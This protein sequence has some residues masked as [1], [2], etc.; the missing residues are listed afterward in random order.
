MINTCHETVF[1]PVNIQ[2]EEWKLMQAMDFGDD[3]ARSMCVTNYQSGRDVDSPG[4]CTYVGT[5]S[6]W[7][8]FV[9]LVQFWCEPK[10][11]LRNKVWLHTY[12]YLA[13]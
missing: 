9:L 5:R 4:S 12:S 1:K 11:A 2:Y 7:E 13:S 10:A 3:K 8:L 6:I